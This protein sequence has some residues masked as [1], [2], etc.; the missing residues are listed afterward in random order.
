MGTCPR[1]LLPVSK[2]NLSDTV[3][4]DVFPFS[5]REILFSAG[6]GKVVVSL[7]WR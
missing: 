1:V 4:R 2:V 6:S 7:R 5:G 3:C